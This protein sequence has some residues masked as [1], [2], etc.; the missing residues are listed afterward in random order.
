MSAV[1]LLAGWLVDNNNR[2]EGG[3]WDDNRQHFNLSPAYLLIVISVRL[4]DRQYLVF[5]SLL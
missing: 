4:C 5:I 1:D 2:A 3:L